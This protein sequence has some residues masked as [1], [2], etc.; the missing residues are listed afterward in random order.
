MNKLRHA[1][2]LLL[3]AIATAAQSQQPFIVSYWIQAKSDTV[4]TVRFTDYDPSQLKYI[5]RQPT[6]NMELLTVSTQQN[7]SDLYTTTINGGYTVN[8]QYHNVDIKP[9]TTVRAMCQKASPLWQGEV[10]ALTSVTPLQPIITVSGYNPQLVSVRQQYLI[11]PQTIVFEWSYEDYGLAKTDYGIVAM[12]CLQPEMP[13]L[14]SIKAKETADSKKAAQ[15]LAPIH[16]ETTTGHVPASANISNLSSQTKTYKVNVHFRQKLVMANAT[17]QEPIVKDFFR[18]YTVMVSNDLVDVAYEKDFMWVEPH[19]NIPLT[20]YYVVR[21][22]RTYSS[23]E[24]LT[25]TFTSPHG[26][27]VEHGVSTDVA[28]TG[29]Y[30]V[31]HEYQLNDSVRFAYH[32]ISYDE[33]DD[34]Y[35]I[36][37]CCFKTGVPNLNLLSW[38]VQEDFDGW[39]F[40]SLDHY[41]DASTYTYKYNPENPKE[42][43]YVCGYQRN[44]DICL[45]YNFSPSENKM[46]RRYDLSYRWYDRFLYLDGQLFDF[47]DYK[48]TYDFDFREE[49]MTLSDGTPARVFTQD[50]KG[51]YLGREF[52]IATVDTVYQLPKK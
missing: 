33:K 3:C 44:R 5:R 6:V 46:V 12:P 37:I 42:D 48:M 21:R 38:E 35:Y 13:E 8:Q 39:S 29:D 22:I 26:R 23:G 51:H 14:V 15:R 52:Y 32:N 16:L 4:S 49:A 50:C 40:H 20:S 30:R 1:V 31:E 7:Y 19:Y 17:G 2:L 47:S 45:L 41:K 36:S 10:E 43:W 25:D 11:G 9:K 18:E 27:M 34:G 24:K 28:G